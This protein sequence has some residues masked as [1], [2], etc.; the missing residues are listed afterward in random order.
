MCRATKILP[1]LLF[2]AAVLCPR[3]VHSQQ[4]TTPS[5]DATSAFNTSL[6]DV[7]TTYETSKPPVPN[8]FQRPAS[9]SHKLV[10][11]DVP[12]DALPLLQLDHNWLTAFAQA[13]FAAP[14]EFYSFDHNQTIA[15]DWDN[16]LTGMLTAYVSSTGTTYVR[17]TGSLETNGQR[18]ETGATGEPGSQVFTLEWEGAHIVPTR[19]GPLEVAAG[20]FRQQLLSYSAFANSPVT[21]LL[22]GRVVS[23]NGF[24]TSLTLPDKNLAF[25]L[26]FGAQHLGPALG[27][28][29]EKSF[30]LSWTW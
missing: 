4:K 13:G 12:D 29:H 20:S 28:A 15:A 8:P 26:R 30:G 27:N 1:A 5:A 6:P 25:S 2:T 23:A 11:D 16:S 7:G 3:P 14:P 18:R 24:E 9:S 17:T 21:D 19:L 10:D 22:P